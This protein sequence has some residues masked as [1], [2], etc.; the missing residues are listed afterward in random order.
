MMDIRPISLSDVMAEL[1]ASMARNVWGVWRY[2]ESNRTL[3]ARDE[4]GY[5]YEIDL[6]R[7]R[8]SA[9]VCDWIFQVSHKTWATDAILDD[10]NG[11]TPI[12]D[13]WDA[14]RNLRR[15][16]VETLAARGAIIEAWEKEAEP[17]S[18]RLLPPWGTRSR[19]PS[20]TIR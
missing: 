6:E 8:T 12:P 13:Q 4:G 14:L 16:S 20:G 7:C 18:R 11:L 2:H 1:K 15:N 17:L 10:G 3:E 19:R 9:E 5:L